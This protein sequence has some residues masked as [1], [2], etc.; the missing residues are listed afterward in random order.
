MY[1]KINFYTV[2]NVSPNVMGSSG[3][4][5]YHIYI[6]LK[7]TMC[8]KFNVIKQNEELLIEC[9]SCNRYIHKKVCSG[10]NTSEINLFNVSK[11]IKTRDELKT[12]LCT[13]KAEILSVK[14]N[15]TAA[16]LPTPFSEDVYAEYQERHRRSSNLM[17][18]IFL[19]MVTTRT[20][21][22]R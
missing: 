6:N 22:S 17:F 9:A 12:D 8:L 15:A 18:S 21:S 11:L 2:T 19:K 13:L 4:N 20:Q 14:R 3:Q 1:C 5:I 16:D 10:L 7:I